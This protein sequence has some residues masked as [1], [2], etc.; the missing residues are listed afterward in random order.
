MGTP[1]APGGGQPRLIEA[2][3]ELAERNP[4]DRYVLHWLL[5]A[6]LSQ[7][8]YHDGIQQFMTFVQ[9]D[10]TN[11]QA[12]M[13]L[14]VLYEKG[15]YVDE[16][17]RTYLKVIELNPE[18]EL[19]YLFLSTR[20]NLRGEYEHAVRIADLGLERFPRAERLHFNRGYA[21]AHLNRHDEA[22]R[23]FEKEVEIN[24]QCQEAYFNIDVI[25]RN[26]IASMQM[27]K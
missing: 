1:A 26:K 14:A 18:E 4:K 25:K 19:A 16:A 27:K 20:Y 24:P 17:I 21:L 7:K 11:D 23:E 6:Y 5:M 13:C 9:A 15:G 22:I 12:L 2:Y 3:R 8:A 10:G